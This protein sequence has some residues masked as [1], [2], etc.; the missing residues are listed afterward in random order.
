MPI[1]PIAQSRRRFLTD[2]ALAGAAGLGG[3][4]SPASAAAENL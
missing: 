2:V 1:A 4:V 3:A